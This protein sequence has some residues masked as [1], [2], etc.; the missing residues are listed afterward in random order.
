MLG[1]SLNR[2]VSV[3]VADELGRVF[4]SEEQHGQSTEACHHAGGIGGTK[5]VGLTK[6]EMEKWK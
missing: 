2:L 5:T 4:Q 1:Q 6:G 3:S